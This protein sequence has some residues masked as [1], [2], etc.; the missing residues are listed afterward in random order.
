[1]R[2]LQFNDWKR[3][4][5][6]YFLRAYLNGEKVCVAPCNVNLDS[7]WYGGRGFMPQLYKDFV[8]EYNY[9]SSG[10]ALFSKAKNMTLNDY[11]LTGLEKWLN[12][13][14]HYNCNRELGTYLAYYVAR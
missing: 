10:F 11:I 5:K 13:V 14:K 3:V 8:E 2:N 1:M 4:S 9:Y 12:E 6:A 7:H